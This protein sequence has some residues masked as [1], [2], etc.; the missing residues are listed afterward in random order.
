M[1]GGVRIR[2]YDNDL[3]EN[4]GLIEVMS[5]IKCFS[6]IDAAAD[7]KCSPNNSLIEVSTD[8]KMLT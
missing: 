7:L 8:L 4:G 6:L 5:D 1:A 2:E 3:A